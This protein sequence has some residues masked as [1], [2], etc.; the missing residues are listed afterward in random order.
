M[1][2]A[3]RHLTGLPASFPSGQLSTYTAPMAT[4]SAACAALTPAAA[5]A[6]SHALHSFSRGSLTVQCI[7]VGRGFCS[8]GLGLAASSST[9]V[10]PDELN[11]AS[12]SA[13][14]SGHGEANCGS[15]EAAEA[16]DAAE[17]AE[18]RVGGGCNRCSRRLAELGVERGDSRVVRSACEEGRALPHASRDPIPAVAIDIELTSRWS[19]RRW[20]KVYNGAL[21]DGINRTVGYGVHFSAQRKHFYG[22]V[23]QSFHE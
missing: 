6:A 23:D 5:A 9:S 17:A 2:R 14:S 12:S 18:A 1:P 3:R 16:A 7:I 20:R 22:L 10:V 11:R 13:S 4:S 8:S 15:E 21:C 19:P